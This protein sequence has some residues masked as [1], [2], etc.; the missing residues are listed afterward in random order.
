[1]NSVSCGGMG[2]GFN[3]I[4]VFYVIL[5]I[6]FT[7]YTLCFLFLY[8]FFFPLTLQSAYS[9]TPG[10]ALPQTPGTMSEPLTPSNYYGTPGGYAAPTPGM[11][12]HSTTPGIY[13]ASTPAGNTPGMGGPTPLNPYTPGTNLL[14]SAPTP[15]TGSTPMAMTPGGNPMTPGGHLS[16]STPG[17]SGMGSSMNYAVGS[18]SNPMS[19]SSYGTGY[20][21]IPEMEVTIYS[22]TEKSLNGETAIIIEVHDN[23]TCYVRLVNASDS[24]WSEKEVVVPTHELIPVVPGPR[25]TIRFV[26]GPDEGETA[27]FVSMSGDQ[28]VV[29]FNNEHRFILYEDLKQSAVKIRPLSSEL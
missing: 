14:T 20:I 5:F 19:S 26:R 12:L 21:F 23:G 17:S 24:S 9:H 8:F 3:F 2:G 22:P 25:D 27:Q 29:K 10:S 11:N 13:H 28:V 6:S 7:F 16:S 18:V 15:M 1:M 4:F